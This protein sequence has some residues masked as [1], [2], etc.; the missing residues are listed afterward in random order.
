MTNGKIRAG[1]NIETTT[2]KV[3]ANFTNGFAQNVYE[4]EDGTLLFISYG[5]D[6]VQIVKRRLL[7]TPEEIA[8]VVNAASAEEGE[9]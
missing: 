5:N 4:L 2:H 3:V 1:E 6:E 8:A 9:E 7:N